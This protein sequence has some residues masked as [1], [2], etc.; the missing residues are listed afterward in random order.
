MTYI[1]SFPEAWQENTMHLATVSNNGFIGTVR[2][3]DC[4][5]YTSYRIL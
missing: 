1:V 5:H 4:G 3:P 2:C